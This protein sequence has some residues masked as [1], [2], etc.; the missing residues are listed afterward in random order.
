MLRQRQTIK[1]LI[2]KLLFSYTRKWRFISHSSPNQTNWPQAYESWN[3]FAGSFLK[4]HQ[5]LS[6]LPSGFLYWILIAFPSVYWSSVSDIIMKLFSHVKLR[7]TDTLNILF[8]LFEF[9]SKEGK[10]KI[11][12]TGYIWCVKRRL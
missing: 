7:V 12:Y 6:P 1:A 8:S 9:I 2:T 11:F 3:S 5:W 10:I 4:T